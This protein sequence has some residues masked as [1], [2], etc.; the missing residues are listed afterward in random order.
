V[1]ACD[2]IA[3][4]TRASRWSATLISRCRCERAICRDARTRAAR[5][6]ATRACAS[7]PATTPCRSTRIRLASPK[8]RSARSLIEWLWSKGAL[9][10]PGG[11]TSDVDS[12]PFVVYEMCALQCTGQ[13]G[14]AVLDA[15][16]CSWRRLGW[17]C[18]GFA[19]S[20]RAS[21][22]VQVCLGDGACGFPYRWRPATFGRR[23]VLL[24][25]KQAGEWPRITCGSSN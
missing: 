2:W 13:G 3:T 9:S 11:T 17:P 7:C 16:D 24:C 10:A 23:P 25:D 15:A 20:D 5:Q 6:F 18:V 21:G 19:C 22:A 8:V 12:A 1:A 4:A 14:D